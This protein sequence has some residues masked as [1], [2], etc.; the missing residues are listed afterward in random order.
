M[1]DSQPVTLIQ[2]QS[3]DAP[4]QQRPSFSIIVPV[5]N[6]AEILQG[7]I[8]RILN[9]FNGFGARFEIVICE[10]GSTDETATIAQRLQRHCSEVRVEHLPAAN[11][12]LALRRAIA[13]CQHDVILLF[14]VDFWSLDFVHTALERLNNYDMV[15][16]S[17][18][19]PGSRDERP[20]VRRLITRSFNQ[21]LRL[22]FGFRGT[23]T[24]GMKAFRRQSLSTVIA[25]CV[26]DHFIFDTE[27]V[28]RAQRAGVRMTEIPVHVRE[29]RQP[30]YLS[31]IR[32]SP[33]VIWNLAK[34]WGALR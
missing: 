32:R 29:L 15:I 26:T 25:L 11:Y 3:L 34:L 6:E 22:C 16:G 9:A 31:L 10:N 27:L 8:T 7:A 28:L 30:S 4:S 18:V 14:N 13:V 24:H 19:M 23:D 21:F 17:K 2:P 1:A 20:V 33:Q 5:H 12:G